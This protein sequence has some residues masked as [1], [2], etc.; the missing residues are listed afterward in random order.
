MYWDSHIGT[1]SSAPRISSRVSPS[2]GPQYVEQGKSQTPP[3]LSREDSSGLSEE[4]E[5]GY[6][7]VVRQG[8]QMNVQEI[9][10]ESLIS[11]VI[12][13]AQFTALYRN[14]MAAGTRQDAYLEDDDDQRPVSQG[15][16]GIAE[17]QQKRWLAYG[18]SARHYSEIFGRP[19]LLRNEAGKGLNQSKKSKTFPFQVPLLQMPNV[20]LPSLASVTLPSFSGVK[21]NTRLRSKTL[22]NPRPK[23]MINTSFFTDK[24]T[25]FFS[26][27]SE[28]TTSSHSAELD[29]IAHSHPRPTVRRRSS[30]TPPHILND[31]VRAPLSR[32]LSTTSSLGD[33]TKFLHVHSAA[34]ARIKAIRDNFLDGL[35]T[36]PQLPQLSHLNPFND[37]VPQSSPMNTTISPALGALDSVSGDVVVMG[38]YRGSI[39]R[40]KTAGN[41]R[42]WIPLKVGLNL[43]KVDL[44]VGLDPED[45]ERIH[46]KIVEGGMLTNIGPVDISK[47]LLKRLRSGEQANRRRVHEWGYDWRLSPEL[48][49]RRLIQFL[50]TLPCNTRQPGGRSKGK[51]ALVIAHSLGGLITRH[52]MNQRPELFSGVIFAGTPQTCVNILGPLRNGDSVM[53]NSKV[54]TAQ[55]RNDQLS[56]LIR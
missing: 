31:P 18:G 8:G 52:A 28:T 44:E 19:S 40:D 32:T 9:D 12:S 17:S 15:F 13:R 56:M 11:P 1:A 25:T 7:D 48:L 33:D 5:S 34:N 54:F 2:A 39:L 30:S 29:G 4:E 6:N 21:N 41:R 16:D 49:S 47:K 51:G 46:E 14:A 10:A 50:E 35:P 43:R 22:F 55:V 53:L 24:A 26:R 37:P 27:P 20:N 23:G 38:G 45:E 3:Q 42:V 36:F